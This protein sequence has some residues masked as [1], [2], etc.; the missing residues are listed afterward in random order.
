LV[1]SGA[2]PLSG[3][4]LAAAATGAAALGLLA[5]ALPLLAVPGWELGELAAFLGAAAA[6]PLG[7]AA[8]RQELAGASPSAVRAAAGAAAAT[9]LLQ[10]ALCAPAFARAA[11]SPCSATAGAAF[12]PLLGLP[13]ALAGSALGVAAG[14]A[15]RGRRL[16]GALLYAAAALASLSASLLAAWAGPAAYVLDH[17]L[18][19]WPGPIYD[20]ALEVDGRLLLFR[21]ATLAW[22]AALAAAAELGLR[23]ARRRPARAPAAALALSLLL[24]GGAHAWLL[25][26]GELATRWSIAAELGGRRNGER[27]D[28][29]YPVEK[30]PWEAE[31]L[32]RDCEFEADDVAAAL[33]IEHPPRVT[34]F[35]YRDAAEKR[36]LVGAGSTDYTKPW[37]HEVH[38]TDAPAPLPSLRH[39]LTHAL[40]ASFARGPL[41][42]PARWLVRVRAGLVEGLAV[43]VDLPRG[44]WTVHQWTRAMRDLGLMP[45]IAGLLGPAGFLSAPKARAYAAAGSFLAFLLRRYGAAPVRRLYAGDSFE[46]AFGRPLPALAGEWSAFLDGVA[47]PDRLRAA[48][49]ARFRG[50]SLLVRRCARE[51]AGLRT[52]AARA[53]GRGRAAEA[54]A[55]WRRASEISG[56]P[57]DLLPA[58]EALRRAGD[59]AAARRTL[60]RAL[61]APGSGRPALRGAILGA[62]G[63]L[64]WLA[65]H[66]PAAATRYRE[67]LSQ[68]P[69][70][71]AARL[72]QAKLGALEEPGLEA[73]AAPWLLGRGDPAVALV[74]LARSRA[75]LA[76]YLAGRALLARG[77]PR[78]ALPCL[79]RALAGPLPSPDFEFEARRLAADARCASGDLRGGAAA[80]AALARSAVGEA[81]R[82]R[83]LW[84]ARR[85]DLERARWGAPPEA[86]ADWPPGAP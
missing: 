42:V 26:R 55:A 4:A 44:E 3:R 65:G 30:P 78:L 70:R 66:R 68:D 67:A 9:A 48:A 39:E 31:R 57:A 36:R 76:E 53:A 17:L 20:E 59:V 81:D 40:A 13:T 43:A 19:E 24:F 74:R 61:S 27:C 5:S 1:G 22:A 84:A 64:D 34:V 35:L 46:A 7:I 45:G 38:L 77:A 18:G 33:G 50:E 37:L 21:L 79:S 72:L 83:A 54:A 73:A 6:A 62:L 11:L 29:V 80:F 49:E 41:R 71:A 56:D 14:L 23:L 58:A 10:A 2:L 16:R 32:A 47:V 86:P 52:R 28:L 12:V 60:D 63:D 82:E 75:P 15:G 8:A 51:V 85:C 25:L 69:E